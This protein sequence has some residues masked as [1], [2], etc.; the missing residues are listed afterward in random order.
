MAPSNV[1][2]ED[3][4]L[5]SGSTEEALPFARRAEV[6]SQAG[7]EAPSGRSVPWNAPG[8]IQEGTV[9]RLLVAC[10][11]ARYSGELRV[12]RGQVLKVIVLEN[13]APV[14]AASNVAQERFAKFCADRGLF[15]ETE[16]AGIARMVKEAGIRTGEALVRLGL[17]SDEQRWE[18]LLRQTQEIVWSVFTWNSG[19]VGF[20]PPRRLPADL[21]KRPLPTGD[22]IL[23]GVA[24]TET[25]VSLRRKLPPERKLFPAPD[26][27]FPLHALT[28]DDVRALLVAQT[29]GTKTVAD[30][31]TLTDLSERDALAALH[32]LELLG[33]VEERAEAPSRRRIS[34]GL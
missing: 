21:M 25:L 30:L 19:E 17:I 34:Y 9:P 10:H 4:I 3:S 26:P 13:G 22:L 27:P 31:L 6:W 29:D 11:R 20:A 18:F 24:R 7:E 28:L 5:E 16:L 23:E 12:R 15:P 32:G 1:G 8:P 2:E 33:A 14:Y